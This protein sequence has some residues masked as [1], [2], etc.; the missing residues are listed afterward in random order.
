ML[1]P[2]KLSLANFQPDKCFPPYLTTPRSL[3]ACRLNGVNPIELVVIPYADFQKDFPEDPDAAQRRYER[4]EGGRLRTL[5]AVKQDWKRLCDSGWMPP[6]QRPKTSKESILVVPPVA[7]STLLELQAAKFRKIEQDNWANLQRSLKMEIIKADMNLQHEKILEKQDNIQE[8]NDRF[9]EELR[10]GMLRVRHEQFM[11]RVHEEE[12]RRIELRNLQAQFGKEA[13]EKWLQRKEQA[14]I[15]RINREK[16]ELERVNRMGYVQQVKNS[17]LQTMESRDNLRKKASEIRMKN[18]EERIKEYFSLKQKAMSD[19]QNEAEQ[20]IQH[21]KEERQR[22]EEKFRKEVSFQ[23]MFSIALLLLSS[24]S[25]YWLLCELFLDA[26]QN[27]R[28]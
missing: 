12:R 18:E 10:D 21:A 6:D 20:K 17:I 9:K 11:D 2:V 23:F 13:K 4:I 7:H 14:K 26:G 5:A 27:R 25:S 28:K 24:S 16:R 19:K 22:R 15:D 8:Q 1:E 3:E